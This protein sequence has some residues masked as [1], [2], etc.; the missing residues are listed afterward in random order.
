MTI[1]SVMKAV[2]RGVT[3]AEGADSHENCPASAIVMR[4]VM[5]C[6]WL[7]KKSFRIVA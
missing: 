6:K 3:L 1:L 7:I 5:R 4:I 2:I